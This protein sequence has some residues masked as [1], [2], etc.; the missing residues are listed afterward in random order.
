MRRLVVL[1]T[2]LLLLF[3]V[4][5]RS[6]AS[7]VTLHY[8]R[9][10]V[11]SVEAKTLP[12]ALYGLGYAMAK[13][14]AVGMARAYLRAQG[15]LAE[16]D[17]AGAAPSDYVL[18]AFGL[19]ELA[20][21][22]ASQLKGETA[23]ALTSFCRGANRS[24]A[25]Q[26][27]RL[28]A[29]VGPFTPADVLAHAHATNSV[30][31]LMEIGGALM[32]P[33]FG[34]NQFAVAAKRS[35]TG[36][37]ILSIDPHLTWGEPFGWYEFALYT[38]GVNF[39]GITVPGLP[40]PTMGHTGQVAWSMTNNDP[41]LWSSF[42]LKLNPED[43][44]QYSYHGQWR[45]FKR[46]V[47]QQHLRL[48]GRMMTVPLA[49]RTTEW[50]P[51]LG[52]PPRAISLGTLGDWDLG[53][54]L[55]MLRA[56]S[57]AQFRQALKPRALSMWNVVYADTSGSIGYQYNAHLARRNDGF[58]WRSPVP[59][60]DPRARLGTLLS[61]D[62]LPHVESPA[63]GLLVN[64]NSA[65]WLT[66]VGPGITDK[67]WPGYVT[68]YGHTTRYDR[69]SS[70]LGADRHVSL[71][72]ARRYATDNRVPMGAELVRL[73]ASGAPE[74]ADLS[75][76]L[77][78][79]RA[80]DGRS[81]VDSPGCALV[82]YW[83]RQSG[84]P[85]LAWKA[86]QGWTPEET[87]QAREALKAAATSLKA[88]HGRLDVPWGQVHVITRGSATVP[89]T[90]FGEAGL[91][92]VVP[93]NGPFTRGRY[94]CEFG[95]SFRMV[96]DLDPKGIRS[97]SILPYGNSGLP[98]SPHYTDQMALFGCGEYK[99]TRFGLAASRKADVQRISLDAAA[100]AGR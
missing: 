44:D 85:R 33:G 90:G 77:R 24:L 49:I 6:Q 75:E 40:L 60:D 47:I 48:G 64:C 15:R 1:S 41:V 53:Q 18:Q 99:D 39:R 22:Q 25:E 8:D 50:G 17:G 92:A 55:A 59:G 88:D 5:S 72:A 9:F 37:A 51:V 87:Q 96:V 74:D 38:P 62:E 12:D 95:S 42:L 13:D 56:K 86:P 23:S 11:P 71:A 67:G 46:R 21:Q 82:A 28:P 54:F 26:K 43:P 31:P 94:Q 2:A 61:L 58:A 89:S 20:K 100:S 45:K 66:P 80:W 4:P 70:L 14:H 32:P 84:M 7:T 73:L 91:A 35:A 76:P 27:G 57:G 93:N 69:L 34:S 83:L 78:V 79:L 97:W 98:T 19:P 16:V 30:F 29:W 63:S 3:G 10:G 81:S 36:H 65:P 52:S 68:S